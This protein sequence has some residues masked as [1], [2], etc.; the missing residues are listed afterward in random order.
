MGCSSEA[1]PNLAAPGVVFVVG[2]IVLLLCTSF[3]TGCCFK[4]YV[5]LIW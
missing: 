3:R 5:A 4:N 2:G 1:K